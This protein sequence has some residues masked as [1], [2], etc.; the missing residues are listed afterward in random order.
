M[1][2]MVTIAVLSA[3]VCCMTILCCGAEPGPTYEHIKFLEPMVG[4]WRVV[5]REGGKIVSDGQ[6]ASEWIL[7]KSFMR[8]TGWSQY[9]GKPSQY[10]FFT[11]W[12][13]KTKKVFQWAVGATDVGFGIMWREGTYDAA[14]RTWTARYRLELS[15]G[16][17]ETSLV[18]LKIVDDSKITID[19]TER[20]LSGKPLADLHDTF[21]RAAA[22]AAAPFDSTPGAGYEHLKFLDFSVGKWKLEAALPDG[23]YVGEELNA[24]VFDKNFIRTKGWGK[25]AGQE[26]VDYELLTG[27]D[28]AKKKVFMR[29]IGS[30]GSVALREGTYDAEKNCLKSKHTAVDASGVESSSTVVE[31]YVNKDR[32][33]LKFTDG[34]KGGKPQPDAEATVTRISR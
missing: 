19:F 1:R 14:K 4:N 15:D 10:E 29:F 27:W 21:T 28:P 5:T 17:E 30:D 20:R 31:Q 26:R 13:P 33:L 9:E 24:W 6:E 7:N 12:D 3:T 22:V 34:M 32:F 23:Q 2:H 16:G 8:H 25:I 11:G 18:N